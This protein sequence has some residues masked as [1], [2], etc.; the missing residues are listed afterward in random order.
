MGLVALKYG[1]ILSVN[2]QNRNQTESMM[3]N[4]QSIFHIWN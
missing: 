4:N 1:Y 2:M 3:L